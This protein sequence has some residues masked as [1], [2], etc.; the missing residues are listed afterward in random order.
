MLTKKENIQTQMILYT[1]EDLVPEDSLYRKIDKYIDFNFIYD[2]VKDLYCVNNGRPCIDPVVLFK[3]VFIQALD[4]LKSMRKTCEKIKV[5]AEY[6]WFLKI[7]FGE[8]TP[9]YST[10]SQNYIRRFKDSDVFEKIFVNIV[11]QAIKY[12]LVKGDTFFTDSTHKKANAN[13]NKFH[14]EIQYTVKKRRE[15]LEEEINEERRKQGKKEFKYKDEEEEKKVKISDTD[16]ES[17]YYHRDNKEKGFMYLDHRTVDSKCNIIVDCYITK[18]NVHDATPFIERAEYIKNK[19]GFQ[20]KRWALDSGYDTLDIKKYLHDNKIFGVIGYRRYQKGETQISKRRFE[21]KKEIDSYICPETGII[22]AY[23]GRIDRQGYKI[24]SEKENCK[25]CPEIKRCCKKQ[26]YRII[27]RHIK[28]ELNEEFRNNRISKEGKELYKLRK[29]KIERSFADSKQNHGYR[30]AMYKGVKKNQNYTWLI[31]AAQNMKNI[32]TKIT[33]GSKDNNGNKEDLSN[34]IIKIKILLISQKIF[35]KITNL[36]FFSKVCQYSDKT[37]LRDKV[38]FMLINTLKNAIIY[39]VVKQV[40]RRK[41]KMRKEIRLSNLELK[42]KEIG[43]STTG[44]EREITVELGWENV[45]KASIKAFRNMDSDW[46]RPDDEIRFKLDDEYDMIVGKDWISIKTEKRLWSMQ[47]TYSEID[48]IMRE[49]SDMLE[50]M[51]A[52]PQISD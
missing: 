41:G 30:Y 37:H 13:K 27:R 50:R 17:G 2:E 1:L 38:C 48:D 36:R 23:K 31:C 16:E 22:L 47:T 11:E 49:F 15:W 39:G 3:L 4:G 43:K 34:L 26:G 44:G 25:N 24:Y 6:R 46:L 7:P 8:S 35:K 12:K 5:D 45:L 33:K 32:V 28:E 9:H 29:E 18:G 40:E 52:H 14:E 21:Y 42:V 19:F 10:F 20:A 51:D